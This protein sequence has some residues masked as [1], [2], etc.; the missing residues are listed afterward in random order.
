MPLYMITEKNLPLKNPPARP[1]SDTNS[2]INS[3]ESGE[4]L[5]TSN[6][7]IKSKNT[8]TSRN[9]IKS[10][11]QIYHERAKKYSN[12]LKMLPDHCDCHGCN[13]RKFC[14]CY[15]CVNS[16]HGPYCT[17]PNCRPDMYEPPSNNYNS[18]NQSQPYIRNNT[19]LSK[20]VQLQNPIELNEKYSKYSEKR[21]S[22]YSNGSS[23]T[24][25]VQIKVSNYILIHEQYY[26][27]NYLKDKKRL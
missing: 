8:S 26:I 9:Q 6:A 21:A 27:F 25:L 15:E 2:S 1:F 3:D 20:V 24:S 12:N 13:P 22:I 17:C 10:P 5:A 11:S 16:G 14:S 7:S 23:P 4:T 19:E 18:P